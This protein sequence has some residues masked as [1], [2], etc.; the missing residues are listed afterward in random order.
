MDSTQEVS[1]R[2]FEVYATGA[3]LSGSRAFAL[4]T[5]VQNRG[6]RPDKQ[7]GGIREHA[8]IPAVL[9]FR[10][11]LKCRPVSVLGEIA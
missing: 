3:C 4:R 10:V 7:G 2:L 9:A 11:L 6:N 5:L 8:V 1:C